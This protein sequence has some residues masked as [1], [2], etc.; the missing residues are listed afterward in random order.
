M[1]NRPSETFSYETWYY[2]KIIFKNFLLSFFWIGVLKCL[3][4]LKGATTLSIMAEHCYA[5]WVALCWISQVIPLCW[6]SWRLLKSNFNQRPK[7]YSWGVKDMSN[8]ITDMSVPNLL[9]LTLRRG[10]FEIRS[11]IIAQPVFHKQVLSPDFLTRV[12][13]GKY[14][15]RL[16]CNNNCTN[17]A[18]NLL[19][20][21]QNVPTR[22]TNSLWPVLLIICWLNTVCLW[23]ENYKWNKK[24]L[25]F[26]C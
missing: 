23:K 20:I 7:I 24:M 3:E 17:F 16:V 26:S 25:D 10:E 11:D 14:A 5:E 1:A 6:V 18:Q 15:A 9:G 21:L 4:L 22:L 12:T 19:N 13:I 2:K 8:Y